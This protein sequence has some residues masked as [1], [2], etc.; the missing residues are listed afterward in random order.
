RAPGGVRRGTPRLNSRKAGLASASPAYAARVRLLERESELAAID[1]CLAAARSGEGR[2]V[3][4][5][6]E[7]G[8]GKTALAKEACSR[9]RDSVRVLWGQC[10]PLQTPRALGPVVDIARAAGGDLGRFADCDDRY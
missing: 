3:V 9:H 7:A 2:L 1:E 6:G 8:V 5:S 10:D 4:V